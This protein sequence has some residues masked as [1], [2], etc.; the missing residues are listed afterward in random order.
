M[1]LRHHVLALVL[2]APCALG[3]VLTAPGVALADIPAGV[4]DPLSPEPLQRAALIAMPGVWQVQTTARMTG[5]RTKD[6][7]IITLPP[8]ARTVRREGTA[9]AVTPDGYLVTATHVVQPRADDLAES[10]YLQFLA[11]SGRAHD[12]TVVAKWVKDNGAVPSGLTPIETVVRPVA[13]GAAAKVNRA[14]APEIVETDN[15]RD[16]AVLRVPNLSDAPA[17]GLD[18]GVDSGTPIATLGFGSADPFAEKPRGALIPAVRTGVISRTGP[19]EN[20]PLRILSFIT[21]E[22]ERGDSGGPAIDANGRVRGVV[23]IK[24][25]AGGGAMAPTD[26]LLRVLDRANVRGWEGRTQG[27]YREAL[28][29]AARFDLAG[30]RTDLR[31]TLVSYPAHGLAAYEITRMGEL[32]KA[33]LALAG[34]PWYRGGLWAAGLSALVIAGVLSVLLWK[35]VNRNPG[36][37]G[38]RDRKAPFDQDPPEDDA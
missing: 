34:E 3:V 9:F 23:L 22:V 14:V 31:R 2:A 10:A 28:A 4:P 30:A 7:T 38:P 16:I 26:Q 17:L 25:R 35:A 24:R 13:A 27:L 8:G 12:A 32:Q 37:L 33:R 18:R 36:V 21:N 1:R 29:R 11:L 19:M 5:L 20:E 6:G 15:L